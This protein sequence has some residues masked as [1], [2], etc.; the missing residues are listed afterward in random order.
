MVV[1]PDCQAHNSVDS[2]FCKR[3]GVKL[4]NDVVREAQQ[5]IQQNLSQGY[6]LFNEGKT[7][8]ALVIANDALFGDPESC[9]ALALKGMC[10]ERDGRMAEG[11]SC[12][13]HALTINPDSALDRIKVNQLRN[14]LASEILV[15]AK[16]DPKID[17]KR[18][19]ASAGLAAVALLCLGSFG[20]AAYELFSGN[21]PPEKVAVN[22]PAEQKIAS[23]VQ[24]FEPPKKEEPKKPGP[25][26]YELQN[27]AKS[28]PADTGSGS[29]P[30]VKESDPI[31]GPIGPGNST[32]PFNVGPAVLPPANSNAGAVNIQPTTETAKPPTK[33]DTKD[34]DP[35][36]V[37]QP[38]PEKKDPGVYEINTTRPVTHGRSEDPVSKTTL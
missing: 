25:G 24:S 16:N 18:L 28:Q 34:P 10:L 27:T 17:M 30:A 6:I 23:Q 8:E 12:Y 15:K 5:V 9:S 21:K 1:C 22:T 35:G 14:M 11:L 29:T 31:P 2:V 7:E 36:P 19:K 3:C 13:E 33:P 38:E 20:Y 37:K 4:P 32:R 26:I